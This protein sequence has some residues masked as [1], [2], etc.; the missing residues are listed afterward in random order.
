MQLK[1][2]IAV[3]AVVKARAVMLSIP[4]LGSR[5][6]AFPTRHHLQAHLEASRVVHN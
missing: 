1:P 6:S 5:R 4:W 3:T 2:G